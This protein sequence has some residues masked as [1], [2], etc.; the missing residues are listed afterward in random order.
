MLL[1]DIVLGESP[2]WHAGEIWFCDWGAG[3]VINAGS[4]GTA[5]DVVARVEDMP[6]CIDWLPDGRLLIIAGRQGLLLRREADGSLTTV[7]VILWATGF[8]AALA[9][10]DP[11]GLRNEAG[12]IRMHGTQVAGEPRVHLVGFGPSQSTVGA[13][14]AGREAVATLLKRELTSAPG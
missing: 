10:L 2:R 3:E 7:D 4:A 9:H 12:G 13:N 11:L 14:R 6:F 1:R 5:R 8:K